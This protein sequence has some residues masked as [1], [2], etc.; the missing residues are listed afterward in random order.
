MID[1]GRPNEAVQCFERLLN[2]KLLIDVHQS[3]RVLKLLLDS[4]DAIEEI[5]QHA[6]VDIIRNL[7][8][9][10]TTN[11][12]DLFHL[13]WN[14]LPLLDEYHGA[15]PTL[16]EYQLASDPNFFC[17]VIRLIFR[18][19]KQERPKHEPTE[20]Q[21]NIATNAYRLLDNWK[22]PPGSSKDGTFDGD[23]LADWLEKVKASSEESGHLDVALSK[24][25]EVLIYAPPDPDG[26]WLHRA[27]AKTLNAKDAE[28]MRNGYQ[29]AWHNSRGVYWVD[30]AGQQERDLAQSYRLKADSVDA[31]GYFRL[32]ETL[33]K[34]ADSYDYEAE[35]RISNA[36][37]DD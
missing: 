10:P 24:L 12:A 28:P 5:D 7:Q 37:F 18:S 32:A 3:V 27:V 22:T 8:A 17:E 29:V 35:R 33:R 34:I 23:A 30:P 19:R 14:F 1:H 31:E 9:D 36:D 21:Q 6:V 26:L 20:Q 25:G 13:E 2:D 11:P 16:L 4:P 15:A